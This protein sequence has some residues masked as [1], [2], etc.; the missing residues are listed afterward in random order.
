[1]TRRKTFVIKDKSLFFDILPIV[2][3]IA[4]G[5]A[6]S[7]VKKKTSSDT[8]EPLSITKIILTYRSEIKVHPDGSRRHYLA[9]TEMSVPN[10]L[11]EI[12]A[13]VPSPA[14][15]LRIFSTSSRSSGSFFLKPIPYSSFA[16]A[17]FTIANG[18]PV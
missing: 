17:C 14:I 2:I 10:H 4:R 12:F 6:K 8:Q 13:T 15:S 18:S 7:R 9:I 1:M 11:V 16:R 3:G 5:I